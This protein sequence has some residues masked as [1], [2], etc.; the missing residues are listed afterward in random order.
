MH[1]ACVSFLFVSYPPTPSL[2]ILFH[3]ILSLFSLPTPSFSF[4][5]QGTRSALLVFAS[6]FLCFT[7]LPMIF[8]SCTLAVEFFTLVILLVFFSPSKNPFSLSYA[9]LG[10]HGR[11]SL[12]NNMSNGDS[13]FLFTF[14]CQ[15]DKK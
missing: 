6:F 15:S 4:F 12:V 8:L 9:S 14:G 13:H 7:L 3:P 10:T 5:I 1:F 11:R 2:S